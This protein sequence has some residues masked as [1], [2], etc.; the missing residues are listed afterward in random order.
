M[1]HIRGSAKLKY[2]S[3]PIINELQEN[4]Y[5]T[6]NLH[7]LLLCAKDA[8]YSYLREPERLKLSQLRA[9]SWAINKPLGYVI[10]QL[11]STPIKSVHYLNESY[12]VDDHL[13]S[14]R[15]K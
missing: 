4:G 14:L 3:S 2:S 9:I 11:L 12:S 5:N 7:K 1:P 13:S 6:K 15:S 10:N 8:S